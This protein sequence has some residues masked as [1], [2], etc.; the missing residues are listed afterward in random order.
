LEV[1]PSISAPSDRDRF[2]AELRPVVSLAYRY[3]VRLTGDRDRGMDLVQDASLNAFRAFDQFRDGTSF[4]AWFL[5]ILTNRY[6][7]TREREARLPSVPIDDAPDLFLYL[8]AKKRGVPME[9]D[10]CDF[11]LAQADGQVVADALEK[12]PDEYRVVAIL[13]LLSEASYQECAEV[14]GLPVGT[15]RSRLHRARKLLQVSLWRIAE[16]RGFLPEG[17]RR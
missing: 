10:P 3:A 7:R 12:L 6:L 9:G 2:E 17:D 5:R 15:V 8:E 16:E 13:H 1:S 11:V 4:Q 14:L